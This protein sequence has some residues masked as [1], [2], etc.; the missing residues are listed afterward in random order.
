MDNT[1]TSNRG[2]KANHM[3]LIRVT[4][5]QKERL[6]A[7]AEAEGHK[8]VSDYVRTNLLNPS[9]EA[10]LNQIISFLQKSRDISAS[11]WGA[12]PTSA[13]EILK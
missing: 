12:I 2:E 7:L 4:K 9:V 11:K 1:K 6:K 8:T 13:L 10:K 5:T 3:V